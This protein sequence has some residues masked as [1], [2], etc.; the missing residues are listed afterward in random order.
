MTDTGDESAAPNGTTPGGATPPNPA[1]ARPPHPPGGPPRIGCAVARLDL[2]AFV[3]GALAEDEAGQVRAHLAT[4]PRCR[5]EYD[6]LAGLPGLLARLTEAEARASGVAA[7]GATPTRLLAD[8]AGRAGRRRRLRHV[9]VAAA[10]V[11]VVLAGALGWALGD[12]GG[13]GTTAAPPASTAPPQ[14]SP[15]TTAPASPPPGGR[16]VRASD[17]RSGAGAELRY[18]ATAWGSSVDLTLSGIRPGTRCQLDV[19]GTKGRVETASSWQVPAGGYGPADEIRGGTSIPV[20]EI[21]RFAVRI[22]GDG[23]ELLEIPPA[24]P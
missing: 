3:L 13:D 7:N 23:E 19:Y 12:A 16:T 4:C 17:P 24:Q 6:E 15:S 2:G 14:P 18:A 22:V 1:P 10:A 11:L 8:A 5:A 9:A 20:G 21:T